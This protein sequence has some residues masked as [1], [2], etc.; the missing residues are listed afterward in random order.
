MINDAVEVSRK[1]QNKETRKNLYYEAPSDSVKDSQYYDKLKQENDTLFDQYMNDL[2][3]IGI[4]QGKIT[5][6]DIEKY[7]SDQNIKVP[8]NV[9]FMKK[10]LSHLGLYQS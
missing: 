10:K 6:Q 3:N 1:L 7:F 9:W 2:I 5:D 4:F 8:S